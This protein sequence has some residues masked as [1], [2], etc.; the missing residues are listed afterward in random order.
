MPDLFVSLLGYSITQAV[1][2]NLQYYNVHN[3]TQITFECIYPHVFTWEL[4]SQVHLCD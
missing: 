4:Q 2:G 1:L 3:Y